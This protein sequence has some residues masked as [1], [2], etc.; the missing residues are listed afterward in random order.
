MMPRLLNLLFT[1]FFG[2]FL[3]IAFDRTDGSVL[4][5]IVAHLSLNITT[6]MG[7]IEL[8]S[9]VFGWTLVAIFGSLALVTTIA[10]RG[11]TQRCGTCPPM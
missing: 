9:V 10:S 5:T 3:V 4:A 6:G 2:V 7:G 11:R 8:S 1:L